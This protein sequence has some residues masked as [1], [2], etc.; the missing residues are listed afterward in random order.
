MVIIE[1]LMWVNL[2]PYKETHG[3]QNVHESVEW[4]GNWAWTGQ[5]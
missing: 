2:F 3:D 5:C 4:E 1:L